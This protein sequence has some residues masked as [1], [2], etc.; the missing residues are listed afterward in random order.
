MQCQLYAWS[1]IF[2]SKSAAQSTRSPGDANMANLF[3]RRFPAVA[4]GKKERH[5]D[6]SGREAGIQRDPVIPFLQADRQPP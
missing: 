3:L 4:P 1:R 5:G 2:Q 6:A